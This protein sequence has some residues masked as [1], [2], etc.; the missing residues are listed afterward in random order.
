MPKIKHGHARKG[1]KTK[2]Y[3]VWA[4]M[5]DRCSNP[6]CKQFN[7]YGGRG[8]S[9]CERW[10]KFENFLSDVGECPD[11]LVMDRID[12]NGNY[13]PNNHRWTDWKTSLRNRNCVKVSTEKVKI[14]KEMRLFGYKQQ[15]IANQFNICQQHVSRIINN[16]QWN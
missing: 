15:E 13:E 5:K 8:I 2:I 6:N 1:K 14:I 3:K 12:N 11:G 4:N 10:L 16:K 9:V 7:D